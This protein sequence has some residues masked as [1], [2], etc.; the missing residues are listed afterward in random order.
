MGGAVTTYPW[1]KGLDYGPRKGTLGLS[2]HMT[3][4]SGGY[5]DVAWLTQKSGESKATWAAR[6]SGVSA[7]IVLTSDGTPYQMVPFDNS[8]GNLN[9]NDRAGE[10]GYY[11]GHHLRDVLGSGWTD[12]NAYTLSMEIAGKRADGP[13]N[14][15]VTAAIAWA[16]DMK[17]RYPSL[18][19][20]TGH[21]DQSPKECPGLTP[22]M[23]AIFDGV[24]GHGLW[25]VQEPEVTITITVLPFGGKY[26]IKAGTSPTAVKLDA[27]GKVTASKTWT[28]TQTD[29]S[30]AYD[31]TVNVP[32]LG[33]N[34]FLRCT[35]GFFEDW[36]LSAS[37]VEETPNP[38]N[39]DA[40]AAQ[41]E[42]DRLAMIAAVE[43]V[44]A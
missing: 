43:E 30:A 20:A 35:N 31:A 21:H 33:G 23:R 17:A 22:N 4:G 7:H 27:A 5:P 15:Q 26:V 16:N 2:F 32:G 6:V 44:Y 3:E 8:S 28:A 29:S 19:G 10:Y 11:G 18:R 14:A 41:R 42:R 24:G 40:I 25:A 1:R 39:A 38:P 13:T 36:L 34:P 12:P 9:P 37:Q